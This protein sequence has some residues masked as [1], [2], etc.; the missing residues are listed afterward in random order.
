MTE[1]SMLYTIAVV[2][3]ILWLHGLVGRRPLWFIGQSRF[4]R[5]PVRLTSE[6]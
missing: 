4:R 2:L 1:A 5:K 3:L 6:A